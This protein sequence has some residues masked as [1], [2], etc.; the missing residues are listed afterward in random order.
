MSLNGN[1]RAVVVMN[2]ATVEKISTM[3]IPQT[4]QGASH[5]VCKRVNYSQKSIA[6]LTGLAQFGVS[7]LVFRDELTSNRV[8]RLI[9]PLRSIMIF[10]SESS[11][12]GE[13]AW[14]CCH[15]PLRGMKNFTAYRTLRSWIRR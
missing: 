3:A 2:D 4:H 1:D 8:R 7:L 12:A 9:G 15:S 14:I 5:G 11:S 13:T 10:E 6:V